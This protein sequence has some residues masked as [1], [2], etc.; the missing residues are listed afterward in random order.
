MP[1]NYSPDDN[2]LRARDELLLSNDSGR[3]DDD[4]EIALPEES[5]S[6]APVF[7]NNDKK[8]NWMPLIIVGA[9][10]LV[11]FLLIKSKKKKKD[12]DKDDPNPAPPVVGWTPEG[13]CPTPGARGLTPI[14]IP[15]ECR[16][17]RCASTD[18]S[19]SG[20]SSGSIE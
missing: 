20:T 16:S 6:E 1:H 17:S 10:A 18:E 11:L 15:P 12:G 8:T 2:S 14:D 4:F 9:A 7:D 3:C 19:C 13:K 5:Q